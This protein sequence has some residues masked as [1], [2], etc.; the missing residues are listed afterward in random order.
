MR[1]SECL[2]QARARIHEHAFYQ[3]CKGVSPSLRLTADSWGRCTP[4]PEV[5]FFDLWMT[6]ECESHLPRMFASNQELKLRGSKTIRYR[7]SLNLNHCRQAIGGARFP[8]SAAF[9]ISKSG[10]G[11]SMVARLK[12]KGIDGRAPPGVEPAA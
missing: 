7:P 10:S 6:N 4:L 8:P 11:G 2:R 3:A 9:E 12:L 1:K 5:K